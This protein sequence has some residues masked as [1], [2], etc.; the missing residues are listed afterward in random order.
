MRM[1]TRVSARARDELDRL[2]MRAWRG[3]LRTHGRLVKTL[4]GELERHHGIGLTTY[5]VLVYLEHSPQ[6]QMRMCDLADSILLS[7]SGLTRLVD[8]LERDGLLARVSCSHDARGAYAVLTPRGRDKL[9]AARATHHADVRAHFLSHFTAQELEVLA[10]WWERIAPA[11][12][13]SGASRC[14]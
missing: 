2:E 3:L 14:G 13:P 8:R 6:R 7:R 4:D 10:D 12:D 11:C 5:E 1:P 9:R